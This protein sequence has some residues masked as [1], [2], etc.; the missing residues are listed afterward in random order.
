MLAGVAAAAAAGAGLLAARRAARRDQERV[1]PP[2]IVAAPPHASAPHAAAPHASAPQ[3]DSNVN[4]PP[5][6][7]PLARLPLSLNDV[8]GVEADDPTK[9]GGIGKAHTERWLAGA[10][11][12]TE[13]GETVGAIFIAPEGAKEEAVVAFA[14]PRKDIGW[15]SRVEVEI[16]GEPPSSLEIGGIVMQRKRRLFV[17]LERLGRGAPNIGPG[18]VFA[19]YQATGRAI[20][21]VLKADTTIVA[22]TG[23]RFE[24]GEYERWGRG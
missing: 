17:H 12:M 19:E 23:A 7:D 22:W 6:A 1:E 16:I 3:N 13:S 20:A 4:A 21:V 24:A 9:G 18:A 5:K 11:A 15:V 2:A 10:L 14:A 8:V